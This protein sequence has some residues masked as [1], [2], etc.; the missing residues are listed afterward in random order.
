MKGWIRPLKLSREKKLGRKQDGITLK[1]HL[2]KVVGG[3]GFI[4]NRKG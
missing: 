1:L 3:G 2:K 4:K